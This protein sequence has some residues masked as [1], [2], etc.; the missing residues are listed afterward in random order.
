M[1]FE[2]ILFYTNFGELAF[3]S[4]EAILELKDAGLKKV[5]LVNVIP[6]EDVA[7]VPYGGYLKE[8]EDRLK[9][10]ARIRFEEWQNAVTKKGIDCAF[11]IEVGAPNSKILSIAEEEKV[12]MIVGGRKK[13][14]TFEKI[15][16]GEHILDLL[17]RSNVPILMGKYK[18]QFE[19]DGGSFTH[20]NDHIFK[21]PLLATDWSQP[22]KNALKD[23]LAFKGVTEKVLVAHVIGNKISKRIDAPGLKSLKKESKKRL[24]GFCD[25]L[26][27]AGI[28]AE[29]HLS[30]GKSVV[31]IIK[32]SREY[33]AT[34]IV[35]GKTGKDWL[36]EYW[37]GGV[38]HKVAEISE[39][40][41][42]LV[43]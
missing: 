36:K 11:R 6:R 42:L 18:V 20:I 19:S 39:L 25:E 13:R 17:R 7:F 32:L 37:L 29:P 31:E 16:V 1:K 14:T 33:D 10:S 43:P 3:N 23:I 35:M 27:N 22:S 34:M 2:K 24:K 9:E 41:V 8:E 12:D 40:P 28:E 4:L 21:R 30:I 5:V 26:S 15:Y 38:S